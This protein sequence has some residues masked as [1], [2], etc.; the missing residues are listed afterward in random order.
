MK[1]RGQSIIVMIILSLVLSGCNQGNVSKASKSTATPSQFENQH[2]SVT[3][4]GHSNAVVDNENGFYL[5]F[6]I[7]QLGPYPIDDKHFSFA[8]QKTIEDNLGNEYESIKTEVLTTKDN[9][10]PLPE[11]TIYFR[12]YFKPELKED[13]RYL[14]VMFFAKPLYYKKTLLF[15]NLEHNTENDIVNDLNIARVEADKKKLT[16]YIEDVHNIQGLEATLIHSE[17][18]IYPIFAS[19][20]TSQFNHSVVAHYEFAVDI[21]DPFTLKIKRH[22]LQDQLWEFPLTITLN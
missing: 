5:S 2:L 3:Y 8:L 15:E 1:L 9:G 20:E 22:R 13:S 18:E 7:D 4:E 16:L 11:K 21:P 12:Q 14:P 10:E 17:E 19:T 6:Q